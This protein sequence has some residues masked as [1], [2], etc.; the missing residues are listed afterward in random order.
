MKKQWGFVFG[1]SLVGMPF[2]A[3]VPAPLVAQDKPVPM[4]RAADAPGLL[5]VIEQAGYKAKFNPR[6][7]SDE[8][9]SIEIATRSGP[10]YIQF[11]DCENAVPDLCETL[12]LSS[13]WDR[14]TPMADSVIAD[15]NRSYKYVSIWKDEDG[16]PIMQWAILTGSAGIAPSLF[17]NGL[18]RYLDVVRDFDEVAFDGDETLDMPDEPP[19]AT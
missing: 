11:S 16:D 9:A 19:V 8:S 3:S 15:A 4:V 13:S 17:L 12:V 5:K 7:V 1:L 2:L 10:V 14:V 6:E 18:Q